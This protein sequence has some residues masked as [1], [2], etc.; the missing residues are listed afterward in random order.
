MDSPDYLYPQ[1][2]NDRGIA[3]IKH[4]TDDGTLAVVVDFDCHINPAYL[5]GYEADAYSG[6]TLGVSPV[7]R[8]VEDAGPY[9]G[10]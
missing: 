5:N 2:S 8:T 7:K 3:V 1:D 10:N 4:E 6:P 9:G